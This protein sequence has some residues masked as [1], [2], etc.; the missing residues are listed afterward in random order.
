ME[1]NDEQLLAAAK[2]AFEVAKQNLEKYKDNDQISPE[3]KK[4]FEMNYRNTANNYKSI[5]ERVGKA[6]ELGEADVD[7]SLGDDHVAT[8]HQSQDNMRTANVVLSGR[9]KNESVTVHFPDSDDNSEITPPKPEAK[10]IKAT[11]LVPNP[12]KPVVKKP[13]N[14]EKA[15]KKATP[16]HETYP[17]TRPMHTEAGEKP[18]Q[19][20][21]RRETFVKALRQTFMGTPKKQP[22]KKP[23]KTNVDESGIMTREQYRKLHDKN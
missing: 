16:R 4:V 11:E 20:I 2:H 5:A 9:A 18:A 13:S 1:N 3:L 14:A 21:S 22:E 6:D 19:K 10:Q 23:I 15:A 8:F 12:G 17:E 7:G